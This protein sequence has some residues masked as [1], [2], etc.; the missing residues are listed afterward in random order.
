MGTQLSEINDLFM[1]RVSDYRINTVYSTS[2][3]SGLN[4]YLEPWLLSSIV[5]FDICTQSLDYTPTSGSVEGYF[6][7]DLNLENKIIL[8]QLM[9][10]YWMEK[11]IQDIMQ[12][13]LFITDRDFKTYSSAQN[14]NAKR[15]YY[16]AKKEELMQRLT[17]YGYKHND[18]SDWKDQNFD[19][20]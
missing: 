19:H 1:T 11:T 5:D 7:V 14:L 18:W 20:S 17:L 8:S 9:C 15:S 12:M 4:D 13:S 3:S 16:N 10:L 2:G 6:S